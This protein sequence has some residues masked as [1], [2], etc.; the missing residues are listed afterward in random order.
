MGKEESR[1]S[2]KEFF[3]WRESKQKGVLEI[4]TMAS[5]ILHVLLIRILN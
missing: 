1:K 3:K 5:S 4:T 2:K